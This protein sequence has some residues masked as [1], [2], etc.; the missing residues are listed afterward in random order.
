[1]EF[2]QRQVGRQLVVSFVG[3]VNLEGDDSLAFKALRDAI[4][5]T[6]IADT[7]FGAGFHLC[8]QAGFVPPGRLS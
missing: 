1:M 4:K 7:D 3:R 6:R 2:A 5:T 8:T